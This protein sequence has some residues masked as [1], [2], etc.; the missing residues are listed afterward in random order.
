MNTQTLSIDTQNAANVLFF[1][2]CLRSSRRGPGFWWRKNLDSTQIRVEVF[3]FFF[4]F[5]IFFKKLPECNS[6]WEAFGP[7]PFPGGS[8]PVCTGPVCLESVKMPN[9]LE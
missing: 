8:N 7:E 9:Q 4:F 6:F 3:R 5:F 2:A 1:C